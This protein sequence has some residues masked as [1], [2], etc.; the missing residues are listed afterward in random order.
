MDLQGLE[1]KVLKSITMAILSRVH[2]RPTERREEKRREE[3]RREPV[4]LHRVAQWRERERERGSVGAEVKDGAEGW[5]ERVSRSRGR[6]K[7]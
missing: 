7:T 1:N 6:A 5:R 2:D 4:E 3:K